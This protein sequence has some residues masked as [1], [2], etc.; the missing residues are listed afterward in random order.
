MHRT[1]TAA[2]GLALALAA[3]VGAQASEPLSA[4]ASDPKA[5]GWMQGFPPPAAKRIR[6][7]DDDYFAF[8][9]LRWTVCHFRELMPTAGVR[10]G[11]GAATELPRA[12]DPA[13]G[14]VAFT[15]LGRDATMTWDEA[16]KAN[17]TDGLLVRHHGRIVYE[18][19]A[20][21]LD[22][23]TLHGVM[24]VT[25]SLTGLMGEVLVARGEL[26]ES[27]RMDELI[28]ELEDSGFG[29]ATVRQVLE[30]TTALDYS[31]DYADPEAGVW[32]YAEAASPLPRPEG[33][34]G[35]RGISNS[36]RRWTSRAN[37]ARPSATGPSTPTPWAG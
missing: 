6:F 5:M 21:C 10:N 35:P 26:D 11:D 8:P 36:C 32:Q 27:Q 15:P 9:K 1:I 28:P 24:S 18:R 20:G 4:E 25:K 22:E 31:E 23:H 19:Y 13:I 14:D 29:D 17:Y 34:D 12:I 30:M 33:Y 3:T 7:T 2:A 37:T 16:F